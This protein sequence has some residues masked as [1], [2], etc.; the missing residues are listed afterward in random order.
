[1]A[2]IS[3]ITVTFGGKL[4]LQNYENANIEVQ[5]EA[6]LEPSD[7]PAV[8]EADLWAKAKAAVQEQAAPVLEGRKRRV[9]AVFE[10]LP[11]KVRNDVEF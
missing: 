9:N 8:V 4:N 2:Y 1:M 6:T 7:D 3:R 10:S 11:E 5:L